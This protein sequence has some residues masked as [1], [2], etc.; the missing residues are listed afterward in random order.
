MERNLNTPK[1]LETK[2]KYMI[3]RL[4]LNTQNENIEHVQ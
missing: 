3:A 4:I 1:E 2:H